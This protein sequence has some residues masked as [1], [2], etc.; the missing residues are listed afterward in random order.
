[1]QALA[2]GPGELIAGP[3]VLAVPV[4]L[5]AGLL[6]FFS[7]C[8]LPLLPGYLSYVAGLAGS[9]VGE[10]AGPRRHAAGRTTVGTALFVLGFA[11]L[12]AAYGALFGGFGSLLLGHQSVLIRGLGAVTIL[13]G[14]L[15][16]GAFDRLPLAGRTIRLSYRPRLGLLGAPVLGVVFGLGWT[17]CVGPTLAAVLT[18]AAESGTAARGT[19]LCFVYSIGIG[20]PFV[21]AAAWLPHLMG[22]LSVARRH[23]RTI[24]RAG[25]ALLIAV[26]IV[27]VSGGWV[28]ILAALQG[29]IGGYQLPL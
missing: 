26:G 18:L 10:A 23:A 5:A 8:T 15:F 14:L 11:A 19:L 21:A 22:V 9:E 4:A 12:F 24:M 28:S 3:L 13:L 7:P 25:G 20:L 2:G 27:Q 1:M 17:P 16:A 6:A 29:Y